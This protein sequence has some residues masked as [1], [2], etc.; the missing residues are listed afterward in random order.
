MEDMILEDTTPVKQIETRSDIRGNVK[1]T[2]ASAVHKVSLGLCHLLMTG[3]LLLMPG[4][5]Y[6][7]F[8]VS[9]IQN[10]HG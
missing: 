3:V 5:R 7:I 4:I 6:H 10:K 1:V 8:A 9:W 2:I